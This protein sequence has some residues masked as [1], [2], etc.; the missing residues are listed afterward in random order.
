MTQ[1]QI[2]IIIFLVIITTLKYFEENFCLSGLK[3]GQ[4]VISFIIG[5]AIV[6]TFTEILNSTYQEIL[7]TYEPIIL[8]IPFTLIIFMFIEQHIEKH[9]ETKERKKEIAIMIKSLSFL[10]SFLIGLLIILN[11]QNTLSK[12]IIF[13]GILLSYHMVKEGAFHLIHEEHKKM[14]IS[15]RIKQAILALAAFYGVLLG[16]LINISETTNAAFLALFTGALIYILIRAIIPR[17]DKAIP[18]YFLAGAFS[19]TILFII[20]FLFIT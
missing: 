7:A 10:T 17:E 12:E 11:V 1:V 18:S 15:R 8:I 9:K 16:S 4:K 13:L 20:D 19:I 5:A 2:A 6:A 14:T 3:H